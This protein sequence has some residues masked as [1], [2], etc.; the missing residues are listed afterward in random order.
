MENQTQATETQA[1]QNTNPTGE[2]VN[3]LVSAFFD[4]INKMVDTR[5]ERIMATQASA[6]LFDSNLEDRIR[7]IAQEEAQEKISELPDVEDMVHDQVAEQLEN[8]DLDDR[9]ER[10][11]NRANWEDKVDERIDEQVSDSVSSELDNVL[12]DKID[13]VLDENLEEKVREVLIKIV[14]GE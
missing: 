3:A 13:E 6:A 9:V 10:A 7:T 11:F 8:I 2:L 1:M 14:K 4:H 5:V 12:A